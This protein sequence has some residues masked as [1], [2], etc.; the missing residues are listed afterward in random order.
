MDSLI[1]FGAKYLFILP[2]AIIAVYFLLSSRKRQMAVFA[3]LDLVLTYAAG[4]GL[5]RVIIDPRPFVSEQVTPLIAH[6]PDN[7]FPSD[8]TLLVAAL[9][10]ILF[11]YNRALGILVYVLALLIGASRVLAGVHHWEDIIGSLVIAIVSTAIIY[12][13]T[14]RRLFAY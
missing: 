9:A 5:N 2:V 6:A 4:K 13:L 1:I 3:I 8:H 7:G 12:L 10:G 11:C 14:R